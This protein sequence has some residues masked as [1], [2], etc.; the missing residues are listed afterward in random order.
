MKFLLATLISLFSLVS[1]TSHAS[2]EVTVSAAVVSSFKSSFKNASEVNWKMSGNFF[3][4]DFTL[5]GQYVAAFYDANANLVAVTRNISSFQLPITLQNKLKSSYESFW[6]SDLF[7][8]SD[9][10][11]TSYY[12]TVED[13]D[14]KV[15]LKSVGANEWSVFQ[16]QRKS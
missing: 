3:K 8:L 15:T 13:G 1:T 10:N 14:S 6:I 11:G 16:K 5:N 7:E 12:V 4:A 9:D 2:D